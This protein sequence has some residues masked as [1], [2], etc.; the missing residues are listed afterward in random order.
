VAASSDEESII[1][2]IHRIAQRLR[3]AAKGLAR[4]A[5]PLTCISLSLLTLAAAGCA[6]ITAPQANAN[7]NVEIRI[8]DFQQGTSQI[9]TRFADVH[10]NTVQFVSG[11]TIACNDQLLRYDSGYVERLL[12]LGAYIGDVPRV[13]AGGAYKFTY[14]PARASATT[15]V[16]DP[17]IVSVNV[18]DAPVRVT[19]PVSGSA[20]PIPK[21]APLTIRFDP[22]SLANTSILAIAVDSRAQVTFTLPQGETGT[23]TMQPNQFTSF[24][25]GPGTL[26]L[27]RVTNVSHGNAPFNKLT[28]TYENISQFPVTWQ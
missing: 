27:V 12:G 19:S 4:H 18:V 16:P 24:N 1:M 10:N 11:E 8:K 5:R 21:S 14:T 17:L 6:T 20:V 3:R 7:L 13:P 23:I 26:S 2:R 9:I 22:V 28:I 15:P 25:P